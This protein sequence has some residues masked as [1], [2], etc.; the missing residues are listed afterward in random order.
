MY[1]DTSDISIREFIPLVTEYFTKYY[2]PEYVFKLIVHFAW[3]LIITVINKQLNQE[4]K[5]D[6]IAHTRERINTL[7]VTSPSLFKNETV[8]LSRVSWLIAKYRREP[9]NSDLALM[10]QAAESIVDPSYALD[11]YESHQEKEFKEDIFKIG[12]RKK[13]P[14][15]KK[16]KTIYT[17]H[18]GTS[19]HIPIRKKETLIEQNHRSRQKK[20]KRKMVDSV[21]D[22]KRHKNIPLSS[23][24]ARLYENCL[25]SSDCES[26]ICDTQLLKCVSPEYRDRQH[27]T[28]EYE[29][30]QQQYRQTLFQNYIK[31]KQDPHYNK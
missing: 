16:D 23:N 20:Y 28:A 4:Q 30:T 9:L 8:Y 1:L 14:I 19:K 3:W 12:R 22:A 31:E 25:Q 27:N 6:I 15:R 10:K 13:I 21:R 17:F 11:T 29:Q 5:Q 18:I 7:L 24:K 26:N 2:E